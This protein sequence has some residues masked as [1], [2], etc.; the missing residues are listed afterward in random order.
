MRSCGGVCK[1]RACVP[2]PKSPTISPVSPANSPVSP[3]ISRVLPA[4]SPVSPANSTI[5]DD[6]KRQVSEITTIKN[7]FYGMGSRLARLLE[8]ASDAT[9]REIGSRYGVNGNY[10]VF[11]IRCTPEICKP[12][13]FYTSPD[14]ADNTALLIHCVAGG[15]GAAASIIEN[16]FNNMMCGSSTKNMWGSNTNTVFG[17]GIYFTDTL[18]KALC[19]ARGE[20]AYVIVALVKLGNCVKVDRMGEGSYPNGFIQKWD[21]ARFAPTVS[22]ILKNS[23]NIARWVREDI[24]AICH[25]NLDETERCTCYTCF[26]GGTLGTATTTATT[27]L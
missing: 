26:A 13:Q 6:V 22:D 2:A 17:N 3:A 10:N 15:E 7:E 19:Y 21:D 23:E 20:E 11:Q 5:S 12:P 4:N 16:G 1:K 14:A 25:N 24:I 8:L 27:S 9:K 18:K